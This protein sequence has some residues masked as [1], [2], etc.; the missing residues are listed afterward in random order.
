[1]L[2][3]NVVD[4]AHRR[5]LL[6]AAALRSG[7]PSV[8]EYGRADLAEEEMR[9]MAAELADASERASNLAGEMRKGEGCKG[10]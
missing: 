3:C 7:D 4:R 8:D 6:L 1:M 5:A 2:V 9:D 10:C